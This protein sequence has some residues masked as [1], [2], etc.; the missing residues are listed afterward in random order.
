MEKFSHR[1]GIQ[2]VDT[3]L[4]I[5]SMEVG[6]RKALWNVFVDRVRWGMAS[7]YAQKFG[8]QIWKYCFDKLLDEV[9]SR[10]VDKVFKAIKE[11]YFTLKWY[12]VYD[13][14]EFVANHLDRDDSTKF[15]EACNS[16][17]KDHLSAYRFVGKKLVPATNR[18]LLFL[19]LIHDLLQNLGYRVV[20]EP[21]V[22]DIQLDLLAYY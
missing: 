3:A 8:E 7:Y 6:L 12:E 22:Q 14:V 1:M 5:D 20:T 4:Q 21:I 15:V 19:N 16:V 13:F 10:D 2:H 9:P 18:E 17:L 11:R